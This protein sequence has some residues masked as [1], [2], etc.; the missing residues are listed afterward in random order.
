MLCVV[1][2]QQNV[3][4]EGLN[5]SDVQHVPT[6]EASQCTG[7]GY[8][9]GDS[10][11]YTSATSSAAMQCS[12]PLTH[13]SCV[14]AASVSNAARAEPALVDDCIHNVAST[15]YSASSSSRQSPLLHQ[16]GVAMST[17]ATAPPPRSSDVHQQ[18]QMSQCTSY[19]SR[20]PVLP[21]S[22]T[23]SSSS[24]REATKANPLEPPKKPLTPYM[25]F[26]KSV[27]TGLAKLLFMNGLKSIGGVSI[28]YLLLYQCT[29]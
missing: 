19:H 8:S 9:S 7:C 12:T 17:A 13:S 11:S 3:I 20:C 1:D 10:L 23:S 14:E 15:A 5:V 16:S 22:S 28:L 18:R 27:R 6:C 4:M 26:S 2:V 24:C 21:S 29:Y 25:R